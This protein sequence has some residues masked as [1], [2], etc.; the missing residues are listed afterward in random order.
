MIRNRKHRFE[1]DIAIHLAEAGILVTNIVLTMQY[2]ESR[3][4]CFTS[5]IAHE[6]EEIRYDKCP[7][8]YSLTC[9]RF[10]ISFIIE[11]IKKVAIKY[12]EQLKM[13]LLLAICS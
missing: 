13:K 3:V 8:R 6:K 1:N 9:F 2:A 12:F 4:R 10:I 11:N 5:E 7:P